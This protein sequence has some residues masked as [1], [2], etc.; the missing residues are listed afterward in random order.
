MTE[1]IN[2]WRQWVEENIE[3]GVS[4][5][6]IFDIL[7]SKGFNYEEVLSLIDY[8]PENPKTVPYNPSAEEPKILESSVVQQQNKNNII[9]PDRQIDAERVP[10]DNN[11]VEMYYV[12]DVLTPEECKHFCQVIDDAKK[13]SNK[14]YT[15][16]GSTLTTPV[17][18]C[19]RNDKLELNKLSNKIDEILGIHPSRA[20]PANLS[21]YT[22]DD[23]QQNILMHD[24]Y[25][26]DEKVLNDVGNRTWSAIIFLNEDYKDGK[27]IFNNILVPEAPFAITPKTGRLLMWNNIRNDG[28][29]NE[30]C[31]YT[32]VPVSS[33]SDTPNNSKYIFSKY[34]RRKDT[35]TLK[36]LRSSVIKRQVKKKATT[37][38]STK[39]ATTKK[40]TKTAPRSRKH[41]AKKVDKKAKS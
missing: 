41:I 8:V 18:G 37:K 31:E 36:K 14:L 38:K 33:S 34:Y 22:P 24:G 32:V 21:K 6:Q 15:N 9:V 7:I 4:K 30:Y 39:N 3:Y 26:P 5:R 19:L 13:K 17:D 29:L 10:F 16:P 27:I 2:E 28:L 1:V 23:K 11:I 25:E 35:S 40:P 12:D 20:E